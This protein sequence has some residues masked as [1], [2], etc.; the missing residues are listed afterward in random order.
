MRKFIAVIFFL[1]T[2]VAVWAEE[3][4]SSIRLAIIGL[5]HDAVGDF[6]SRARSHTDVQLVGVVEPNQALIKTYVQLLNLST[7][8]FYAD[9]ESLLAKTNVQAA[10]VFTT[11][12]G[13]RGAVEACAAHK[14]D[15]MLEKPLA[16][17]LDDALAMAAAA[18]SNGT[19][20]V[21]NYETSWYS[22]IGTAYTI[23]H[24]QHSIGDLRKI[25]VI[26][27]NQGP[28]DAGC[29]DAFLD[30]LTNPDL[31]GGGALPDF[32]CYGADLITWF[33]DDQRPESVFAKANHFKPE[34][35]PRVEDE[36]TI[37]LTYPRLQGIVQ[38]SWNLPFSE[39]SL[40]IYGTMGYVFAP[41]MDL[42]R[43]RLAGTEESEL[44]LQTEPEPRLMTDDI[45]YFVAVVR[46]E[47]KPTGPSSLQANLVATEILD[48]A[49]KSIDLGKQIDLPRSP[50]W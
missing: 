2:F 49:R 40:Q 36:A 35:Y 20:I 9:L 25:V 19:Q 31:N 4:K 7:N 22:S 1:F 38:A 12:L 21:V 27:G 23:V 43:L 10:A 18:K 8:F 39:R 47:I 14:I 48:A 34:V 29:S 46:R 13:H 33:M 30:W 50:A 15:V 42:L 3:P 41:R 32:G 24:K 11:T 16:V 44:E 45:S 17:N 26:A 5:D 28:K 37:V 6:I